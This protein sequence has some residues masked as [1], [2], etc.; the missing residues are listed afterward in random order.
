MT[1]VAGGQA[2]A[3]VVV[4]AD[5]DE[6]TRT[7]AGWLVEYVEKSTGARLTVA[8]DPA[9][10]PAGLA[11]LHVGVTLP[12]HTGLLPDGLAQD[13]FVIIPTSAADVVIL[14]P[15]PHGTLFGVCDFLERYVGVRWLMPGPDGEDVPRQNTLTVAGGPVVEEPAF[16]SR[17][18][19]GLRGAE[20][21]PEKWPGDEPDIWGLRQR[22][23]E[24]VPANHNLYRIFPPEKYVATHPEFFPILDGKRH[25]PSTDRR[26]W[27]SY[28]AEWQPCFTNDATVD[29]A[30]KN[31]I[32]Y[33]DTHPQSLSVSLAVNDS[34][35]HC[36]CDRCLAAISG[37]DNLFGFRDV[38][39]LY[40]QWCNRVVERVLQAH[41]DKYFGCLAYE[42]VAAPPER[43]KLHPRLVP[44]LTYDRMQWVDAERRAKRQRFVEQWSRAAP[45]IGW[46]DYVYG[47]PYLLPRVYFH[48]HA[49]A[50]RWGREHGVGVFYAEAYPN[51]GEGPKLY[52]MLRLLWNP[53]EDVDALLREWYERAVGPDAAAELAA[54]YAHWEDFWTN[55]IPQTSWFA[56]DVQYLPFYTPSYLDE[57]TEDDLAR[58][59]SLLESVVAKAQTPQQKRRAAALLR[60]FEYYEAS[61]RAYLADRDAGRKIE[62]AQQALT[63]FDR[64]A[65][66]IRLNERRL[67]MALEEFPGD[68]L[69]FHTLTVNHFPSLMGQGWGVRSLWSAL[70]WARSH[71][72]A[73]RGAIARAAQ[74]SAG[75]RLRA[76]AM[77]MR[78]M[79][80]ESDQANLLR[81]GSFEAADVSPWQLGSSGFALTKRHARDGH[82]SLAIT[83]ADSTY[84]VQAVRLQPGRYAAA[85]FA[86]SD[87]GSPR[88]SLY[89]DRLGDGQDEAARL[90]SS[91]SQA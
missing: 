77:L 40:Y 19:S 72:D 17:S 61:A 68:V 63:A 2:Q 5:A 47:S 46:Y 27:G 29:E 89:V 79:L 34:G 58:S 33:F 8:H 76:Q 11:R 67:R 28:L 74:E 78:Q 32:H 44:L 69:L 60:A 21:Y 84:A 43:V 62:S 20:L 26:D 65:Q 25:L 12:E 23:H 37:Q 75:T 82:Q 45:N 88:V 24:V 1:I 53:D 39:D 13:G 55:R 49:Q 31:I 70:D 85:V 51:W 48:Q 18:I 22:L 86:R 73:V 81:N 30:V 80:A 3:G 36:E 16:F 10:L 50:I 64:G 4:A 52:V 35:G 56:N 57:V 15:T 66:A 6:L 71:D 38:S 87:G 41:P 54:Y 59:R 91:D 7:A 42:G 14:G 90:A 9:D 83:E